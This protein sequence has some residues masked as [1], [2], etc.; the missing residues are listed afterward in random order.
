LRIAIVGYGI[1]GIAAAIYLRRAGHTIVHFE[2]AARPAFAG[3]GL[4]LQPHGQAVLR[5]LGLLDKAS[6][7]GSRVAR[8]TGEDCAAGTFMNVRYEE[9]GGTPGLGIQ[10]AALFALLR[11]AD[12]GFGSLRT[13]CELIAANPESGV[14]TDRQG[15][16]TGPFDLI[17]VADGANS[18]LRT[19]T[20]C[21]FIARDAGY[22]WRAF[23]CL[24][25][26]P[27]DSVGD[28][29]LQR[30]SGSD[31]VSVWPVG[32]LNAQAPRRINLSCRLPA[33]GNLEDVNPVFWKK[34]VVTLCPIL[35]PL[36]EQIRDVGDL[37]VAG[38]RDVE[39]RRYY[40]GRI[41]FLGDAAHSMSPQL[42]Q[43]ASMALRDAQVLAKTISAHHSLPDALAAFDSCRRGQMRTYQ[44][45]SRIMTPIFQS[46]SRASRTIRNRILGPLGRFAWARRTMLEVL[47]GQRGFRTSN[48]DL[49]TRQTFH[50]AGSANISA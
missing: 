39:L 46:E 20:M 22:P 37:I 6:Q 44:R 28:Q 35:E 3:G 42:G 40:R 14:L 4:L 43:G 24:L 32:Q 47:G 41:V 5:D 27:G 33:I 29:L 21:G 50:K 26:D 8:I 30:F 10:R 48:R 11:N 12:D 16:T 19:A 25:N 34:Q 38:Y 23:L 17:V 18:Q 2:K 13:G 36:L 9:F 7:L 49:D 15:T 31:H 45:L 1:A